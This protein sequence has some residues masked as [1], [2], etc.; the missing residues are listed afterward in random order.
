M[1]GGKGGG[2]MIFKKNKKINKCTEER[3]GERESV[4]I[5]PPGKEGR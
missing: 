4:F 1:S 3:E 2:G 5:V